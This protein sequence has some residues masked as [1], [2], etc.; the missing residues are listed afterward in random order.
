MPGFCKI[1]SAGQTCHPGPQATCVPPKHHTRMVGPCY[2]P[3]NVRVNQANCAYCP[4]CGSQQFSGVQQLCTEAAIKMADKHFERNKN[5]YLFF[6]DIN[7]TCFCMLNKNIANQFN[8]S[9]TPNMI[10]WNSSMN[11]CS[12]LEQLET[13]YSK[14]EPDTTPT[15]G[16]SQ[17]CS[18]QYCNLCTLGA[19]TS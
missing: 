15:N 10:G 17:P 5:H 12:I 1:S 16:T 9:N 8:V 7:R 13:S 11:I 19:R 3:G 4:C 14:P 18:R 2:G 6:S